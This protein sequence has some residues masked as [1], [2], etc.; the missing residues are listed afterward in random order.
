MPQ[1][2]ALNPMEELAKEDSPRNKSSKEPE[3][4]QSSDERFALIVL[5]RT[6]Y[7]QQRLDS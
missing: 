1:I 2:L 3:Q 4:Y 7:I 5:I 6:W